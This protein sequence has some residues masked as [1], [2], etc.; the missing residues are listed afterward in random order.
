MEETYNL[1]AIVLKSEPWR[2]DGAMILTYSAERGKLELAARGIKKISSKL[3]GH[4]EPITFSS[5]MAVR[6]RHYDYVGSAVGEN[7]YVNIKSDLEKLEAAGRIINIFNKIVKEGEK[8][9]KLFILLR[10]A[11]EILDSGQPACRTDGQLLISLFT[12][13]LLAFLGHKPELYNCVVCGK[14]ILP[15]GN[16][17]DFAKGGVVCDKCSLAE[18][19]LISNSAR[20]GIASRLTGLTISDNCIKVL[21]VVAENDLKKTANINIGRTFKEENIKVISSFLKFNYDF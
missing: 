18:L 17:F 4:L 1:K 14:K 13:K 20:S 8:D 7:C 19:T 15:G 5:I 2:E 9:E 6:G 10:G 21:R 3:A 11:L 16:K 12:L